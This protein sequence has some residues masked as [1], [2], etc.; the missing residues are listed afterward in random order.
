MKETIALP[1]PTYAG[2]LFSEN[3]I[4]EPYGHYRAIRDLGPVVWLFYQR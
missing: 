3:A 2:D 1:A 4:L